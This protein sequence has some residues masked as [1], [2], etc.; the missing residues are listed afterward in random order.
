MILSS[1]DFVFSLLRLLCV[2]LL[3]IRV[4]EATALWLSGPT[5]DFRPTQSD[6]RTAA[7]GCGRVTGRVE[8]H[9]SQCLGGYGRVDG[10]K[11]LYATPRNSQLSTLQLS[12]FLASFSPIFLTPFF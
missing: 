9:I 11:P 12:T 6:W 3:E 4:R 10:S 5:L 2:L 8:H 7:Y 1:A